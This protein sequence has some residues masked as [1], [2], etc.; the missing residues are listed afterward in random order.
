MI[1]FMVQKSPTCTVWMYKTLVDNGIN[2]LPTGAG[3]LPST[4]LGILTLPF[5]SYQEAKKC[6][7]SRAQQEVQYI[8]QAGKDLNGMISKLLSLPSDHQLSH[9]VWHAA[10]SPQK[11]P[12]FIF[13]S[14]NPKLTPCS[15]GSTLTNP[16][17]G[18]SHHAKLSTKVSQ[19]W[20]FSLCPTFKHHSTISTTQRFNR[21]S[22]QVD[23]PMSNGS[24]IQRHPPW[25]DQLGSV[26]ST[27]KQAY[28]RDTVDGR[29]PKQP[30]FGCIKPCE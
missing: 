2:Y 24:S 13:V 4:A 19:I 8:I 14:I 25:L 9:T 11:A 6:H 3:F 23:N 18:K 1:L 15:A 22:Q 5:K 26:E 20:P 16:T 21:G 10:A 30:P 12:Q 27:Y 28:I 7:C 29:N 17:D